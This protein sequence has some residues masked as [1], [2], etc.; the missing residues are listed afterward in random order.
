M[1]PVAAQAPDPKAPLSWCHAS[2]TIWAQGG[3]GGRSWSCHENPHT[4]IS[5]FGEAEPY[6]AGGVGF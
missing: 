6:F 1:A 2:L 5:S 3:C 4:G